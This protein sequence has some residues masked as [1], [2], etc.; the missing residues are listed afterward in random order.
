MNR[1]STLLKNTIIYALGNI[2]SKMVG[3]VLLPLYT[4]YLT[5]SDFG[6]WDIITTT[7]LFLM[8]IIIFQLNDGI[9]RHILEENDH[10]KIQIVISTAM[11]V[12]I[13]NILLFTLGYL[14]IFLFIDFKYEWIVIFQ[15]CIMS[16]YEIFLQIVRGLKNSQTYA[17][18]G[19]INSIA[20]LV[21]S[22]LFLKIFHLGLNGLFISTIL[23]MVISI[24]YMQYKIN[25]IQYININFYNKKL[26][27][28]LIKYSIPL[29]PNVI[30]WW[31]M[32]L[33]DRYFIGFY[34]GTEANGLYAIA[35]KLPTIM[36]LANTIFYLAWQESAIMNFNNKD[37]DRY[38]SKM[39]NGYLKFLISFSI[40]LLSFSEIAFMLL[41]DN[42]YHHALQFVP[43]LYLGTIFSAFSSFYG[44]GYQSAKDTRGAFT[45]S[46]YA[47]VI[48]GVLNLLLLPIIGLQGASI[49]TMLAFLIMWLLRIKQTKKYFNISID[50][51]SLF[52]LLSM[53]V[54][55]LCLFNSK[56]IFA[57]YLSI[58]I[59][60][61]TFLVSNKMIL[62]N[63]VSKVK[64]R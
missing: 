48:N 1:E 16:I 51:K 6:I 53:F 59:A 23:A 40:V 64:R 63:V 24:I 20:I 14:L 46:V 17:F 26:K 58:I 13:R 9:Y 50:F 18:V 32:N 57:T 41:I 33:S 31:V 11:F 3:F 61:I 22:L 4:T 27:I 60:L 55:V 37:R 7:V 29:I 5:V 30:S 15:V 12:V 45:T 8:P 2:S 25:I 56:H 19:I 62:V 34:L 28:E 39:F 21:F 47:A 44:T 52:I 49:S 35:N 54:I 38:Y 10:V 42:K 36:F 43:L